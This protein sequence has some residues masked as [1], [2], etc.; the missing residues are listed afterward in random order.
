[1]AFDNVFDDFRWR[2]LVFDTTVGLPEVLAREKVT[3]YIGFDPSSNSLQ[4][5]NL[6][7]LTGLARLQ[8]Y[9]HTPLGLAGGFG[10]RRHGDDRRPK[11]QEERAPDAQRRAGG[12]QR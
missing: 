6:L 1:M 9:G 12:G 8:R 11:R 7:A 5:G 4:V 3:V 10:R 2:G